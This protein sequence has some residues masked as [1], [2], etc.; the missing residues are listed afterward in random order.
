M[1]LPRLLRTTSFRFALFYALVFVGSVGVL[2]TMVYLTV[3]T[4]LEEKL[5]L[6]I[7][8]E[9]ET[10][11]QDYRSQGLQNL[12]QAVT[13][14]TSKRERDALE[15]SV[16]TPDNVVLAG[17]ALPVPARDG[18]STM[19][20]TEK[21]RT[22]EEEAAPLYGR[23]VTLGDGIRLAVASDIDWI[24]DV[25]EAIL[26][27]F[28]W[29]LLATPMLALASGLLLSARFLRGMDAMTRT[30]A[31][32]V[33]GD[34]KSRVPISLRNDDLDQLARAFNSMLDRLDVL[35][36]SLKQVS[37]DIAHDLRTPL[38]RLKQ[39]LDDTARGA[40]TKDE[41]RIGILN[42]TLQVDEILATFSA[43][44][45]IAQI[46]SG[47]RRSGFAPVDLSELTMLL[48]GDYMAVAEDRGQAVRTVVEASVWIEGDHDLLTQLI[49]NL[50][51][52]A[53]RHT[54]DGSEVTISLHKAPDGAVLA[55]ADNGTGVPEAERERIFRRFYRL[56]Q[57]RTSPGSGLGLSLVAAIAELHDASAAALDNRPGLRVEIRFPSKA[58]E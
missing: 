1:I 5:A 48:A 55:V 9:I 29:A 24:D 12:I 30:A 53:L 34:L 26:S 27:T 58:A 46:E 51:E 47:T 11:T 44:L 18:W 17:R 41:M 16:V 3:R 10:L 40:A 50:L 54:S 13:A 36:D 6:R 35:M 15:Y 45:R 31:S 20:L 38:S 49:V 28:A 39:N 23:T 22:S 2:G 32:I 33:A 25:Q 4:A 7:N 42:A 56:E 21:A 43:L 14:R 8:A 37:N 19:A 52:N 57:S